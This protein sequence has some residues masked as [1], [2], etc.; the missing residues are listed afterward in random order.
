MVVRKSFNLNNISMKTNF[1]DFT[2]C[3]LYVFLHELLG[4]FFGVLGVYFEVHVMLKIKKNYVKF[5]HT[6]TK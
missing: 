3:Q 2:P 5:L 1:K 4:D 6:C